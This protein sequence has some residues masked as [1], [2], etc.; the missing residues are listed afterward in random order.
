MGLAAAAVTATL[1]L[2]IESVA[3]IFAGGWL[4]DRWSR[5]NERG[6]LF[7]QALGLAAS[8][9]FLMLLGGTGS[10]PLLVAALLIFGIG[11]GL[12]ECNAM[13]VLCQIARTDLRAT[14]YGIFNAAGCI[15]GGVVAPVAGLLKSTLGLGACLQAAGVVL[16]VGAVVLIRVRPGEGKAQ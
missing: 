2:Q 11:K 1:Y 16:L 15:A 13:P 9:P 12:Y 4:A 8:A 10:L 7:T 6:R 14:G 3:G 5:T